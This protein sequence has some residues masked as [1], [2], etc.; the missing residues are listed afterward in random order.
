MIGEVGRS[1]G[2][3]VLTASTAAT[4]LQ[5]LAEHDVDLVLLDAGLPDQPGLI[6]LRRIGQQR[7]ALP[8]VF[9][10]GTIEGLEAEA[11]AAGARGFLQKPLRLE[12]LTTV[13]SDLLA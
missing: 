8:V 3:D 12:E 11:R 13:I 2:H 1:L 7:P 10:T 5:L 4:G 6:V 9:M